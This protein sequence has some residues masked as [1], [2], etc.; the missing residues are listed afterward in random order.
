[1]SPHEP[2]APVIYGLYAKGILTVVDGR[3]SF[4]PDATVTRAEAAALC[5]R[6][7][8]PEQRVELFQ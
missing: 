4:H 8:R 1:V 7:A 2:E 6:L 3:L 5:A